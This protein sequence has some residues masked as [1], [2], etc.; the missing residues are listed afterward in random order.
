MLTILND[1]NIDIEK[2]LYYT[3]KVKIYK[4]DHIW[5]SYYHT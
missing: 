1:K 5:T 3:P 4:G 2:Y